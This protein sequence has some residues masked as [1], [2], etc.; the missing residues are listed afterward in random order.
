MRTADYYR[1]RAVLEE[2]RARLEADET[3]R[4]AALLAARDHHADANFAEMI[5]VGTRWPAVTIMPIIS[6]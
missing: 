3:S 6:A 1:E 5:E 4:S 2:A